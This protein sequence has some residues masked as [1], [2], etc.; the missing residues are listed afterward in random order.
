MKPKARAI[1][2]ALTLPSDFHPSSGREACRP[3]SNLVLDVDQR[4]A[5]GRAE[6][7]TDG[8]QGVGYPAP[9][10]RITGTLL[11]DLGPGV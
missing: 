11:S 6:N 5:L 2:L 1:L 10:D 8:A 4:H 9:M 3:S 7:Q